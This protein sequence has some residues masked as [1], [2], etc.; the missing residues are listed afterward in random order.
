MDGVWVAAG[1]FAVNIA[2]MLV[3]GG[4]AYARQEARMQALVAEVEKALEK[5]IDNMIAEQSKASAQVQK[6]ANEGIKIA[7]REF[8]ET[9][10]AIRQKITEVELFM[11]DN[12]IKRDSFYHGISELANNVKNLGDSL[13]GR[14]IRMENKIDAGH[15]SIP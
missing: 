3:G 13:D 10:T 2:V 15:K 8:G 14:L 6:E 12:Y 1:A 9:A 5:K 7:I 11:R 4:I